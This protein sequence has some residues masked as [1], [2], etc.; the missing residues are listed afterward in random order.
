MKLKLWEVIARFQYNDA[1]SHYFLGLADP[2]L[3]NNAEE[4]IRNLYT[5]QFQYFV[6]PIIEVVYNV[7]REY[8]IILTAILF[9]ILYIGCLELVVF[10]DVAYRFSINN[11]FNLELAWSVIPAIIILHFMIMTIA[12]LYI[13]DEHTF[14]GFQVKTLG[15]Q[16]Y[17]EYDVAKCYNNVEST[18][19]YMDEANWS[20][21][22]IDGID[23]NFK[24]EITQ[25]DNT[26][27]A[28]RLLDTEGLLYVPYHA[29]VR[30]LATSLDVIHSFTIPSLG[31]KADAIPGRLNDLH[32]FLTDNL[33]MTHYFGQCSELCGVGHAFMPIHMVS[34]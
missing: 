17:W 31:I 25:T 7:N 20:K 9:V 34:I 11:H 6:T 12:L 8:Y 27:V 19:T 23:H 5:N 16:W 30:L 3:I 28:E 2:F 32:F 14:F 24:C 4:L 10:R 1:L 22:S 21:A 26:H 18:Y 33:A 15:H 29:H 13:T